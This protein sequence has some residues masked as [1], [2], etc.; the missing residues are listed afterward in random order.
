MY[1][2]ELP[3]ELVSSPT[4]PLGVCKAC[5]IMAR[6]ILI[7][8]DAQTALFEGESALHDP[9]R[10]LTILKKAVGKARQATPAV[11]RESSQ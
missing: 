2:R 1:I 8:I 4:Q 5:A 6:R 10:I 3:S 9:E 7:V 11:K